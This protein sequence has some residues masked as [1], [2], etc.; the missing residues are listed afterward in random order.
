MKKSDRKPSIHHRVP[1]CQNGGND[2]TIEVPTFLHRSWHNLFSGEL[3]PYDI[4]KLI[5]MIWL[6]PRYEFIVRIK[7]K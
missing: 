6:D 4:A 3:T 2:T 1:R 7:T 5:N